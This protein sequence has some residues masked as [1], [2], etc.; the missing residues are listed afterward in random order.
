[1]TRLRFAPLALLLVVALT[2]PTRAAGPPF[3]LSVHRDRLL[4]DTDGILVITD[5]GV[6]FRAANPKKSRH[7]DFAAVKQF[8]IVPGAITV[9]TYEDGEPIVLGRDRTWMFKVTG[10][11][12]PELVAFL[13]A[14]VDRPIA[15]AVMPPLPETPLGAALVKNDRTSRGSDGTLALYDTGLAYMTPSEG[16]A[17]FWRFRDIFAVLMLDPYRLQVLAYE[18]GSGTTRTFTFEL[19]Q[20]L[21]P[22]MYDALWQRV[23]PVSR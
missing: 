20:P 13:L 21:P 10:Q 22:G 6:E 12:P 7:W 4:G 19:K 23:N 1:M 2:G 8:R 14:R 17:R 3:E 9:E 11:I 15:T 16:Q 5:Q 18:G